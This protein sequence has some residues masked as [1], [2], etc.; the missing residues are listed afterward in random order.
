[1]SLAAAEVLVEM[2]LALIPI[3]GEDY[4]G[5]FKF[6][7]N[8]KKDGFSSVSPTFPSWIA[9]RGLEA[10]IAVLQ[11]ETV[12]RTIWYDPP[13]ITDDTVEKFVMPELPDTIWVSTSLPQKVLLE[14]YGE[15]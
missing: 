9:T 3:T 8:H 1:M 14:M 11:G 6:W 2:G 13:T 5:F 4:N 7:I 15:K 12:L 10:L